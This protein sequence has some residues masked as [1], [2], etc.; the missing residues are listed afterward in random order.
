[1]ETILLNITDSLRQTSMIEWIG[2]IFGLLTV[3][4]SVKSNILT[5]PTGMISVAAYGIL[6][7]RIHLY[8][9]TLL[10]IFFFLMSVWGWWNWSLKKNNEHELPIT[11]L[12][13]PERIKIFALMLAFTLVSGFLFHRYTDAHIPFWDSTITGMSVTAQILLVKKKFENW[14]LWIAVNILSIG[15]YCYKHVYL[16]AI[17]YFIFLIMAIKGYLEWKRQI[18]VQKES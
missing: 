1:M 5:W 17:L 6:F 9:D 16:T 4:Y 14:I 10:Q 8:A 7:F 18:K 2:T 11:T 15:V 12:S 13:L 3:W